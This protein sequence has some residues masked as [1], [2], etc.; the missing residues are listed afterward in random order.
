MLLNENGTHF[1]QYYKRELMYSK[2]SYKLKI[3]IGRIIKQTFK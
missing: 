3:E 2:F 1:K